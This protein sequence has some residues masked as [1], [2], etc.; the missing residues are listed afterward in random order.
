M[1][2]LATDSLFELANIKPT[3]LGRQ[4]LHSN[5]MTLRERQFLLLLDKSDAI[6]LQA[7]ENLLKKVDIIKFFTH[8]WVKN[9]AN[10][11][12]TA[13]ATI[14]K[15]NKTD[16]KI[17]SFLS[18]YTAQSSV[19]VDKIKP[20]IPCTP[21]HDV[22]SEIA[23]VTLQPPL[24]RAHMMDSAIHADEFEDIMIAQAMLQGA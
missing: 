4:A 2:H 11:E 9:I 15:A 17:Q 23:S 5:E 6:S 10:S 20:F 19:P 1:Q 8:G 16:S 12:D 13:P 14:A 21:V 3:T 18:T 24:V 22:S 7:L